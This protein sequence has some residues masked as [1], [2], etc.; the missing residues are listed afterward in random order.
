MDYNEL[1][2]LIKRLAKRNEKRYWESV[3]LSEHRKEM[4]LRPYLIHMFKFDTTPEGAEF[5]VAFN[6]FETISQVKETEVYKSFSEKRTAKYLYNFYFVLS[7]IFYATMGL[8]L[9]KF[10]LHSE[11]INHFF[12]R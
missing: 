11:F 3:G 4:S 7:L 1:P 5:W 2:F 9:Y 6:Q 12:I 8:F 10:L